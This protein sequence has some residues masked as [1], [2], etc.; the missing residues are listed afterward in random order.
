MGSKMKD[1]EAVSGDEER[2]GQ[3]GFLM[4]IEGKVFC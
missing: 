2:H 1:I 4:L 3:W